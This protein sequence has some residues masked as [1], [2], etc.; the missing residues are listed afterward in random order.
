MKYNHFTVKVTGPGRVSVKVGEKLKDLGVK[1]L[2]YKPHCW[3]VETEY[4]KDE[5][6]VNL[7]KIA[8][9]Q[10]KIEIEEL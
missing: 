9:D 7:M 6:H 2:D 10:A 4:S 1:Q 5:L 8:A 3:D